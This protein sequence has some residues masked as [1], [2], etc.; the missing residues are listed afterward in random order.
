MKKKFLAILLAAIMV[1]T[2][3]PTVAFAEEITCPKC[4]GVGTL[5]HECEEC[6][7]SGYF[8]CEKCESKGTISC[9]DCD[10][11]PQGGSNSTQC[12]TCQGEIG[13]TGC[14]SCKGYGWICNTCH[15]ENGCEIDC[16]DCD[17]GDID[18]EACVSGT[19]TAPCPLC[20]GSKKVNASII[21]G[22]IEAADFAYTMVIPSETTLTE[23][24]YKD[25]VLLGSDGLV[26]IEV[27]KHDCATIDVYY[28]VDLTNG[29][30][31]DGSSHTITTNYKISNS[32][33]GTFAALAEETEYTVYTGGA[34]KNTYIKVSAN[35]TSW[36]AAPVG[37]Y[38]ASVVF[39]FKD[40]EVVTVAD[41]L[42]DNFP[43]AK[44]GSTWKNSGNAVLFKDGNDLKVMDDSGS[45]IALNTKLTLKEAGV[46]TG[47]GEFN[48]TWTF[49]VV[50]GKFTQVT[51]AGLTGELFEV[52][53]GTYS[54]AN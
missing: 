33:T 42:P 25:G 32:A 39:N 11:N 12:P 40:E 45:T 46:Y 30:L 4:N 53:N 10:I 5:S 29:N 8:P 35:E 23:D 38:N 14:A 17:M 22:K 2:L 15:N 6:E 7:G 21:S 3:V 36:N 20:G 51:I 54:V 47:T 26:T 9:P 37:D 52:L 1:M 34:V 18:C 44:A 24:N 16:P 50:N 28:T 41:L 49:T 13:D 48:A 43:T 27:T 31:T 19:V